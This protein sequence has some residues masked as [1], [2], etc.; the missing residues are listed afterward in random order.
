MTHELVLT[1]VSQGLEPKSQGFCAVAATDG[2]TPQLAM[3]LKSVSDY[4]HV[5]DPNSD[6]AAKNPVVYSHLIVAG[7]DS[8][9]HIL[10]RIADAGI[11]FQH[12]P[13][14]FAHHVVLNE[15][16]EVPE[17][18][19][20]VLAQAGFHFT[21]W[22]TPSVRFLRGRP[23][24]SLTAPPP[25]TRLHVI[26][27]ERQRLD[28]Q[29]MSLDPVVDGEGTT[30]PGSTNSTCPTWKHV[31]GDAGWGGVL[32]ATVRSGRQAVILYPPGM[33]VLPLFVEALSMLPPSMRWKATFTT[34]FTTLP[35][36]V[37]CQWKA[38]PADA[39]EVKQ[40]DLDDPSLFVLNLALP[41]SKAPLGPY[42][43]FARHGSEN[44]LPENEMQA[45]LFE[46]VNEVPSTDILFPNNAGE[47]PSEADEPPVS[48]APPSV[49]PVFTDD[50]STTSPPPTAPVPVPP[51]QQSTDAF[52][53]RTSDEKSKGVVSTLL[54]TKSRGMFYTLFGAAFL[55]VL[56]LAVFLADQLFNLGLLR[57]PTASTTTAAPKKPKGGARHDS[58]PND[59]GSKLA[60]GS[61]DEQRQRNALESERQAKEQEAA[62]EAL[63]R[64]QRE[65][66][67]K[68]RFEATEKLKQDTVGL[69]QFLH[70]F[71]PPQFLA[72][73]IPNA[74]SPA[75]SQTFAEFASMYPFGS[76][77][78]F[79]F[80]PLLMHRRIRMETKKQV[81]YLDEKPSR[82]EPSPPKPE[83][84]PKP[85]S[86]LDGPATDENAVTSEEP[87]IATE[88]R[89]P[90]PNRLEWTVFGIDVLTEHAT[91]LLGLKLT[92][93]GLVVDWLDDALKPQF[94]DDVALLSLGFLRFGVVGVKDF[95]KLQ[96]VPLFKPSIVDPVYPS[97][98]FAAPKDADPEAVDSKPGVY[99]V[100]MP[101]AEEPWKSIF[102]DG[103]VPCLLQLNVDV[104][105]ES[106]SGIEKINVIDMKSP[107]RYFVDFE[108][109]IM[110]RKIESQN[111][112][113]VVPIT[114]SVEAV[115]T[116]SA[117]SWTDRLAD[118]I[119]LYE[120]EFETNK[121][122]STEATKELNEINQKLLNLGGAGDSELRKRRNELNATVRS[123]DNRNKEIKDTLEKMPGAHEK[124]V[125]NDELHF[126]YSVSLLPTKGNDESEEVRLSN[127]KS[128]LLLQSRDAVKKEIKQENDEKPEN[129]A[130][131]P[132]ED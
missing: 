128:I 62:Q 4:R 107:A 10:S 23:L 63:K 13:N 19:A 90:D 131:V 50:P 47:T 115:T 32:A 122:N 123:L 27:R 72:F 31:T 96:S 1:S 92:P 71:K 121:A 113:T 60:T 97:K 18:P 73:H 65:A 78:H 69:D 129:I 100:P 68:A 108:T 87:E 91:P 79:E 116:P 53:I 77:L 15:L 44:S 99:T 35:E 125:H 109:S 70:E 110:A 64:Q 26:E 75:R 45:D 127:E 105:P 46:E 132:K 49:A 36:H 124:L 101:F 58:K 55:A 34:C 2:L 51:V 41:L 119:K 111:R 76:A 59:A 94:F 106:P 3:R 95:S 52:H 117:V 89:I 5:F 22:L 42:V 120:N 14:R 112:E 57:K 20:W 37:A 84:E 28:P 39:P 93:D 38:I 11:D 67:E 74:D 7:T 81:R 83:E 40:F 16:E 8:T 48:S 6:D 17:G 29:K 30:T 54:N 102:A 103:S 21:Q 98:V 33:N 88:F 126:D 25:L 66:A 85:G 24:P 80:M 104:V 114:V 118:R 82:P 9:F 12:Q 130:P 43:D 86:K 61:I 56:A